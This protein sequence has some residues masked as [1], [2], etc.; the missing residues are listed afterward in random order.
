MIH[1]V[2]DGAVMVVTMDRPERRNAVDLATL[3]ELRDAIARAR[4]SRVLVLTGA[5]GTF[6]AGADLTGIE[7]EGFVAALRDVLVGL[8]ELPG[9][10]IA[11]VE[12]VALGAGAQLALACDLRVASPSALF[13]IPAARLGLM[14][15]RWTVRR[16]VDLAGGSVARSVLLAAETLSA[17]EAHRCGL[18][19]RLGD[20]EDAMR[21]GRHIARLAPLAVAG[22]KLALEHRDVHGPDPE[23]DA[24]IT[25]AWSSDDAVEGRA[26]FLGK[27]PPE[28]L[29]R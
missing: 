12:G 16:L 13:G 1:E 25:R 15:D 10:A 5:G 23:L 2:V 18:V 7:S 28:F 29:G 27:R 8:T 17:E 26:A 20:V 3:I 9:V 19:H 11:A 4:A 22:H 14:V 6:C 24:A 21:W